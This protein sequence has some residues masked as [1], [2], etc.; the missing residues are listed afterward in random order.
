MNWVA[1]KIHMLNYNSR[2]SLHLPTVLKCKEI[3]VK[4]HKQKVGKALQGW[5]EGE[6]VK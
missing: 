4:Q 6:C 2:G 1:L 3:K 5:G